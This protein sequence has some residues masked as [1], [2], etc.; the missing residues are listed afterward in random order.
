MKFGEE[1]FIT[2]Y[3]E[4]VDYL[5][6]FI[7]YD[8]EKKIKYIFTNGSSNRT[9][10]MLDTEIFIAFDNDTILKIDY[11]FYSLMYVR[12][13]WTQSL[14]EKEYNNNDYILDLDVSNVKIEDFEIEQFT[15]E[16]EINP[17]EGTLRPDNTLYFRKIVFKLSNGKNLCICAEDTQSDGY[18]DIWLENMYQNFC[19]NKE[20]EDIEKV[21]YGIVEEFF[22]IDLSGKKNKIDIQFLA[23]YV[24]FTYIIKF[25]LLYS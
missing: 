23:K 1:Y 25:K 10:K 19:L 3:S 12:Y 24:M 16:Y 15:G 2:N 4:L 11:K 5:N 20:F 14:N 9:G 8:R 18:C 22:N 7:N 17:S 6:F 13:M 21:L